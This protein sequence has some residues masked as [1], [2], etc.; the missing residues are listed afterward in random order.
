M[1][2][3]RLGRPAS[4]LIVGLSL[5]LLPSF[6]LPAFYE[7]F[8]YIVFHWV[9]MATS[10]NILSGYSGYFSLG[11]GAFFGAGV[12]AT[13][14]LAAGHGV[15]FL[16]A[17]PVSGIVSA[18]LGIAIGAVV[19]RV[20]R[21]RGELF[22]L[23]TLA[24]TFVL[25]TIV[26]N[27]RIDGGPGVYLSAVPVPVTFGSPTAT[28]YIL[29]VSVA[30][31]AVWAAYGV[32]HSR[33][34]MGLFAIRDDEDVAEVLGVP[35]YRYKLVAFGLSCLLA[36][37]TGGVHAIF[38]SY[39]TVGETFSIFVPLDV[40]LMSVLG[41]TRH[42]F[43]P[44]VGAV[45][46]TALMYTFTGGETA[47]LNRA[48]TGVTLILVI[49]FLPEGVFGR[50]VRGLVRWPPAP[51]RAPQ[52][53][54]RPLTGAAPIPRSAGPPLLACA[55]V[56]KAFRGIQALAGVSIEVQE[57]EVVGLVGPN[58]SGKSTLIN[59]I[60]GHYQPDAGRIAFD[61][62]GIAG[63][64]AHRIARLGVSRTYQ[65]PRPFRRMTV[66]D[67]VT[68]AAMFGRTVRD[69]AAARIEAWRWLDFTALGDK[70]A[71]LPDQLNLHQRKLLELARALASGPRLVL[72]D[73]VLSGLTSSE[74]AD[75]VRLIQEIRD[76]GA[77]VVFVEHVMRVVMDLADR[78]IVLN[79]G[80][81]IAHGTPRE[82]MRQPDVIK[83]YLGQ[84]YA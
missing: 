80:Q 71:A 11:H 27:T 53:A 59:V 46:V 26:L 24:V 12:Y 7:S 36:G 84:A 74:M 56:E 76:R 61:G 45:L 41:G 23:L 49:V 68:L 4:F 75:A 20:R 48:L 77:T 35:T 6:G 32:Y 82:V 9:A 51:V 60:S 19:F 1:T 16:W 54:S 83:A 25:A 44:T 13:A 31:V 47:V 62:R 57:G 30:L 69:G 55:D 58:G 10:W 14:T 29:G 37:L 5:A 70:A 79:Y 72:L 28:I 52:P 65:I 3:R 39:V 21:L 2:T 66:L 67:N 42:W 50:L 8:L 78:V 81:V 17:L 15:P 22:A 73:E 40:I 34:G 18:L 43:G 63:V 33:W 64:D 38:V